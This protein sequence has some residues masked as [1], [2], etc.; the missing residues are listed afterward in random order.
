MLGID[1]AKD[2]LLNES[3]Q[4]L[5]SVDLDLCHIFVWEGDIEV[6]VVIRVRHVGGYDTDLAMR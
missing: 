3:V 5:R 2:I 1:Y 6:L 4:L